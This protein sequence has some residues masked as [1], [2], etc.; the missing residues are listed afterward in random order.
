MTGQIRE[1]SLGPFDAPWHRVH[2][3]R[4]VGPVQPPDPGAIREALAGLVVGGQQHQAL[5]VLDDNRPCYHPLP[6][7]RIREHLE[8]AV[9]H[10]PDLTAD[11]A[12]D[13]MTRLLA[14]RPQTLDVVVGRDC[15][16]LASAHTLGDGR[17][18][19]RLVSALLTQ[20]RP[21]LSFATGVTRTSDVLGLVTAA[22]L[23]EPRQ[24][25][26]AWG[27]RRR[28]RGGAPA[29][30]GA[31]TAA[32]TETVT[33]P[34]PRP[35]LPASRVLHGALTS[36]EMQRLREWRDSI[37]PRPSMAS[38]VICLWFRA[39]E[40]QGARLPSGFHVPVDTRRY[41]GA[42]FRTVWGNYAQSTY[43]PVSDTT[44]LQHVAA[45]LSTAVA[46][47]WPLLALSV[48]PARFWLRRHRERSAVDLLDR[49]VHYMSY[50]PV[51]AEAAGWRRPS[52]APRL[53]LLSASTPADSR[54]VTVQFRASP[55]SLDVSVTFAES[56]PNAPVYPAALAAFVAG[57]H[58]GT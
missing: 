27:E 53:Q 18:M 51:P 16:V 49:D 38:V 35:D 28:A 4:A 22:Y 23:R 15:L 25:R 37:S 20:D 8:T 17:S 6:V 36:S 21:D 19:G 12:V 1:V 30:S 11:D 58:P 9:V 47:T 33:R 54:S 10:E 3:V 31:M 41:G 7:D 45:S 13:Q 32:G 55:M 44:T 40:R 29:A 50:L 5:A 14:P 52:G 57:G 42:A 48:G 2:T 26:L 34:R 46:S 39:L 43:V 24:L 56:N